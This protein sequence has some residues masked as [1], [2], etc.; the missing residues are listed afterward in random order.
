MKI[1]IGYITAQEEPMTSLS[2]VMAIL[3]PIER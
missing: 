2:A 1:S 3:R